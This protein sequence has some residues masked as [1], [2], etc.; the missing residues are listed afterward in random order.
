MIRD[1]KDILRLIKQNQEKI[2]SF[3]VKKLGLFGSYIRQEQNSES[4]IDIL[5]EFKQENKTFDN[6]INLYS[7]LESLCEKHIELV[8]T[9]SISPY[10]KNHILSEVEYVFCRN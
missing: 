9:E 3:G 6:F 1:K 8:T 2:E 7:L 5:V 4:D 10:I